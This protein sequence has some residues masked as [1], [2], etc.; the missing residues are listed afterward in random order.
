MYRLSMS[1]S[2]YSRQ[3]KSYSSPHVHFDHVNIDIFGPLP[4]LSSQ[5]YLLSMVDW[6]VRWPEP[7]PMLDAIL[8]TCAGTFL[9]YW[10]TRSVVLSLGIPS[11]ITTDKRSQF[12]SKIWE[13]CNQ[14][15]GVRLHCATAYHPQANEL[16][17]RF[18]TRL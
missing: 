3:L 16:V 11:D 15:L 5:R 12:T 10:V 14:H 4:P 13:I 17:E 18:H 6:F 9:A 1:K 2:S 8:N 7:V